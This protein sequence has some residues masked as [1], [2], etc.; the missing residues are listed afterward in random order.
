MG[1]V[2]EFEALFAQI[3]AEYGFDK[4]VLAEQAWRE[5]RWDPLAIGADRN[6]GLMQ[7]IPA[8]WQEWAPQVQVYDPFDPASN[9]RVAAAYLASLRRDLAEKTGISGDYWLLVAYNWGPDNV[10]RLVAGGQRWEDVPES[11]RDYAISILTGAEVRALAAGEP[12]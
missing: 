10:R 1:R 6:L 3:A 8:V 7:V 5:S 2:M 4:H 9:L 11:R 12:R